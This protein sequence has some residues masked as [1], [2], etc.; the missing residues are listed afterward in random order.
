MVQ[1][2]APGF[3]QAL[4]GVTLAQLESDPGVVYGLWSDLS[5]A[6]FNPAWFAFAAANGGEPAI[7]RRWPL[8]TS[9][10]GVVPEALRPFYQDFYARCLHPTG[11]GGAARHPVSHEY[12]CSSADQYRR[13]AMTLYRL[14][15]GQGLLAVN[16]L[17]IERPHD[18][19][20]SG[21]HIPR[22]A[23]YVDSHGFYHQCSHCRR[24]QNLAHPERW[25]WIPEWVRRQP[26]NTSHG[27]CLMCFH[28]YYPGAGGDDPDGRA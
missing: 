27:L 5:F 20:R 15:R 2:V 22:E 10:M 16:S 8:G 6:Y 28:Y 23:D 7:T 17:L 3:E 12:D 21:E 24:F 1:T 14:D 26:P 25:D 9:V 4:K 18:T 19:G 11:T 13:F